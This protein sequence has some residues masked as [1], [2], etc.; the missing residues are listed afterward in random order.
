MNK[1]IK[2]F[3]YKNSNFNI[4]DINKILK[5]HFFDSG[6]IKFWKQSMYPFNFESG[7]KISNLLFKFVS[8]KNGK[9]HK[10]IIL[11]ADNTL[12]P[13]IIGED[14]FTKIKIINKKKS[15]HIIAFNKILKN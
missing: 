7:K 11:D 3:C 13:G 6:S 12:W 8:L 10:I 4:L 1:K 9:F 14:N 5:P 15:I 2:F